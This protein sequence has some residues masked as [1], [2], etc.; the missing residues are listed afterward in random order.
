MPPL[1]VFCSFSFWV[2]VLLELLFL[3]AILSFSVGSFFLALIT[4]VLDSSLLVLA[5]LFVT[6][7]DII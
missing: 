2:P 7:G 6:F 1:L 4:S 3:D 5:K